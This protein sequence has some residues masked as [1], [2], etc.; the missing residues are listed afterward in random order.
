[1]PYN[2]SSINTIEEHGDIA[3]GKYTSEHD[4]LYGLRKSQIL[5][6]KSLHTRHTFLQDFASFASNPV[7]VNFRSSVAK[8]DF[9]L[10]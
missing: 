7:P 10:Y 8:I 3:M 4:R 9:I 5:S 6:L 1:M 2:W